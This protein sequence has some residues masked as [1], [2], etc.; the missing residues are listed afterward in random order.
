[1]RNVATGHGQSRGI[2]DQV[3][4]PKAHGRL[5]AKDAFKNRLHC[6]E[7]QKRLIDIKDDQRESGHVTRL[8]F[9]SITKPSKVPVDQPKV[10]SA[11]LDFARAI[12]DRGHWLSR[13]SAVLRQKI[14][15]VAFN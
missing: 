7:I 6:S 9:V 3:G 12:S 5:L 10:I 4:K 11:V 13:L 15:T 14:R 2:H 8:R 1:E